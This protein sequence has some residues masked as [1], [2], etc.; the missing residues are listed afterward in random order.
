MHDVN[1]L[2]PLLHL[3]EIERDALVLRAARIE[4]RPSTVSVALGPVVNLMKR[5]SI[6]LRAIVAGHSANNVGNRS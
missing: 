3:K 6:S 5:L 1:P 2:G 4:S